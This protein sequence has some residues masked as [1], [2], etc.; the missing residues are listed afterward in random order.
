MREVVELGKLVGVAGVGGGF[1]D[2][3]CYPSCGWCLDVQS[4]RLKSLVGNSQGT[5]LLVV[6]EE[7]KCC[8]CCGSKGNLSEFKKRRVASSWKRKT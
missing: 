7:V 3:I 1:M 2:F 8:P 5:A 4:D 6:D